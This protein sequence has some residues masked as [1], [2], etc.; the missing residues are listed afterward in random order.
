MILEPIRVPQRED[1]VG[2]LAPLQ[3]GDELL[4]LVMA[5]LARVVF[6][7]GL[8][9]LA[10]R[11][12]EQNDRGDI[13]AIRLGD[14]CDL[15]GQD[16]HAYPVVPRGEAESWPV[17][18]ARAPFHVF[19]G[20]AVIQHEQG[21]GSR[22]EVAGHSQLGLDLVLQAAY[23]KDVWVA[24][25]EALVR[26]V[27]NECGAEEHDV[28][29]LAPERAAQLVEKIL[30]LARVGG[31]TIKA[32]NGNFLGSMG[33]RWRYIIKC[34]LCLRVCLCVFRLV[35]WR[36]GRLGQKSLYF[37]KRYY[38]WVFGRGGLRVEVDLV[39]V[40]HVAGGILLC[41]AYCA[42]GLVLHRFQLAL[43]DVHLRVRNGE[44]VAVGGARAGSGALDFKLH[45]VLCIDQPLP[46]AVHSGVGYGPQVDP[47][48]E[49]VAG[50]ILGQGHVGP[51]TRAS[52]RAL[53]SV[54]LRFEVT[55]EF[56]PHVAAADA[57]VVHPVGHAVDR[58]LHLGDVGVEEVLSDPGTGRV[59]VDEQQQDTLEG[60]A[61][62]VHPQVPPGVRPSGDGHHPLAH[63]EVVSK[64]FAAAVRTQGLVGQ[65]LASN[66]L[67]LQLDVFKF[68]SELAAI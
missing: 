4:V 40:S 47:E 27:F 17:Q 49:L 63:D 18:L 62:G 44:D 15:L 19:R 42:M 11:G 8:C 58:N 43:H 31:P 29:K 20:G 45:A 41:C 39:L 65:G 38:P 30:C 37:R 57:L 60:P 50:K 14:T 24:V 2:E 12:V 68:V 28:V 3:L 36:S 52:P 23:D 9:R 32:L 22:E 34:V 16:P 5:K 64:L 25:H 13:V 46:V 6:E 10:R 66:D 55:R 1:Q 61:L 56:L 51:A 21:V 33:V 48:A 53:V 35:P 59:G 54:P 67:V 7:D 26:L